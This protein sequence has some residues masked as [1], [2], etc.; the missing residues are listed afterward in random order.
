MFDWKMLVRR[1]LGPLPIDP[2]KEEEIVDELA[3]QLESSYQEE[4]ARGVGHA[5]AAR[6]SLQHFQDWEKLRGEIFKS[7]EGAQLP[8][9]EHKGLFSPRRPVVWFALALAVTFLLLPSFRKAL[10]LLPL[11]SHYD[12]WDSS[13]F[14]DRALRRLEQGD[15]Q[16]YARAL[17]Y[18]AL[19][20]PDDQQAALAAQ[21]AI[22]LDPQLTWICARVSH[23]N[24]LFP[25]YDPQPWI[26][27]LKVWDPENSYVY[28]LEAGA[29]VH[30]DWESR[31]ARFSPVNGDLRRAL[32]AEPRWR[33]PMEKAFSATRWDMYADRQFV[34]D[35]RV[36]LENNLDR[37]DMLIAASAS[38]QLPDFS[39]ARMY[40]DH[41]LLDAAGEEAA[42]HHDK[43]L[44]AYLR[45]ASLAQKLE[46]SPTDF[47]RMF[48]VELLE[49]SYKPMITLFRSH[50]RDLGADSIAQALD[51]SRGQNPALNVA[52][53]KILAGPAYRAGQIA[54]IAG[55]FVFLLAVGSGI[56]LVCVAFLRARPKSGGA[57]NWLATHLAWSLVILPLPCLVLLLSFFPYSE[58]ITRYSFPQALASTYGPFFLGLHSFRP[59]RFLDV[60]L[61]HMFWPLIWSSMVLF[62]GAVILRWRQHRTGSGQSEL[63]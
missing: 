33:V 38:L 56:W 26:D 50:S 60:W 54:L 41:L 37:P 20:S 58:S 23:A 1:K 27:R 5:K 25:G 12:A 9:W 30:S 36:L 61:D 45:V 57:M 55:M 18:V 6:V 52:P 15:K 4:L 22:A 35:R 47:E 59:G 21:R 24:Y 17:A 8:V 48:G 62:L 14:S 2:A 32:V 31:W 42:A 44:L 49:E 13:A 16:K 3:G 29:A 40:A 51:A 46:S 11:S 43:A 63:N 53:Q 28:L 7:V 10:R 39:L 34:L 19:H